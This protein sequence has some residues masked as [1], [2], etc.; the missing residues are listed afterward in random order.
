MRGYMSYECVNY[1]YVRV[2]VIVMNAWKH[3]SM[4]A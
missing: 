1:E 4:N 3:E 2:N